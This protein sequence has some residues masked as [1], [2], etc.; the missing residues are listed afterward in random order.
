LVSLTTKQFI[1]RR[2]GKIILQGMDRYVQHSAQMSITIF[3]QT[4]V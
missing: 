2:R 4:E 1:H 3:H